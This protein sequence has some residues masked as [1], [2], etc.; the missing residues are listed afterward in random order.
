FRPALGE[1]VAQLLW[2][3]SALA[4][5]DEK[6]ADHSGRVGELDTGTRVEA[7]KK[8]FP[9]GDA[10]DGFQARRD[11]RVS[12]R[13]AAVRPGRGEGDRAGESVSTPR[14]RPDRDA[15]ASP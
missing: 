12:F 1:L 15:A 7:E 11:H 6:R 9:V 2:C 3:S 8:R 4:E 10:V 14:L 13:S 5:E